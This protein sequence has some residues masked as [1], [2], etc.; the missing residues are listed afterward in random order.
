MDKNELEKLVKELQEQYKPYNSI[1]KFSVQGS[2]EEGY[3]VSVGLA[4]VQNSVPTSAQ[5]DYLNGL[6]NT[7]WESN[8]T[9]RKASKQA[10]SACITIAKD[11]P[12]VEFWF[13][14]S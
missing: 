10:V 2:D 8:S 6:P 7:G 9:I 14:R 4:R 12:D 13:Y 1:K 5:F 11:H 3:Y